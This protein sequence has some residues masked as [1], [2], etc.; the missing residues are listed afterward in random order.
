MQEFCP[1]PWGCQH[2][3]LTND[4]N[5]LYSGNTWL[6]S[7]NVTNKTNAE[8]TAEQIKKKLFKKAAGSK[9]SSSL[10]Q[11]PSRFRGNANWRKITMK[12]EQNAISSSGTYLTGK[13]GN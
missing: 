12:T 6:A 4:C 5:A 7:E 1:N 2:H 11:F 3:A 8:L 13:Q 9:P 10:C